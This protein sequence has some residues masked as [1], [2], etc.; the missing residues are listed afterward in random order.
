[1]SKKKDTL[2]SKER[3]ACRWNWR[4]TCPIDFRKCPFE[5]SK[6]LRDLEFFYVHVRG[7][8]EKCENKAYFVIFGQVLKFS[9]I[10]FDIDCPEHVKYVMC[11]GGES[12]FEAIKKYMRTSQMKM[13]K[14][15]CREWR[16]VYR[17]WKRLLDYP[18]L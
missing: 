2:C 9:Q 15:H 11:F 5:N 10:S 3:F 16:V 13:D 18:R 1:M 7:R 17:K 4:L 14:R 8:Y 12:I 6:F